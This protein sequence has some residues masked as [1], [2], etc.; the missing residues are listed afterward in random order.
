MR[1]TEAQKLYAKNK[2]KDLKAMG[3][4]SYII[5]DTPEFIAKVKSFVKSERN[6]RDGK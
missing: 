2:Y 1:S 5:R 6:K 4:V 3:H